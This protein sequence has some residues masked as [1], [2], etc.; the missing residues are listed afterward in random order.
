MITKSRTDTTKLLINVLIAILAFISLFPTMRA[1]IYGDA[2]SQTLTAFIISAFPDLFLIIVSIYSLLSLYKKRQL[3]KI[4]YIILSC[5]IFNTVYGFIIANNFIVSVYG[6]KLTYMPM[7]LFFTGRLVVNNGQ[8]AI[9][10]KKLMNLFILIAIIGILFY[11]PLHFFYEYILNLLDDYEFYY[12]MPRMTS[13]FYTPL[14]FST[15]MGIGSVYFLLSYLKN[16]KIS[17]LFKFII[18]CTCMILSISRGA[19]FGFIL[20]TIIII[21]ST[22]QWKKV[23]YSIS[24]VILT[25]I[26]LINIKSSTMKGTGRLFGFIF[27]SSMKTMTMNKE[28]TRVNYWQ[29]S[30]DDFKS[31][32]F[33]FGLGKAGH[34]GNRFFK[35]SITP[36]SLYSTDGWYLK[37][38]NETGIFGFLSFAIVAFVLIREKIKIKD[39]YD[40]TFQLSFMALLC[41]QLVGSNVLD[42]M[43]IAP[44]I[45]LIIGMIDTDNLENSTN[46]NQRQLL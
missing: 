32:P 35:N 3:N 46:K 17:D 38:L 26:F 4:D 44:C 19:I 42:Y 8:A 13:I 37:L 18:V 24:L 7:F 1:I 12:L 15:V 31:H 29:I 30:F 16:K 39:L 40:R 25:T 5:I 23:M 45:W 21:I 22:K 34:I 10:L 2:Q 36:A 14:V 33:G 43:F 9:L 11:F 28:M 41:L 27:N 20:S 6:F